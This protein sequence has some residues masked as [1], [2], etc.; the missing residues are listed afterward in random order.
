MPGLVVLL[1]VVVILDD[2]NHKEGEYLSLVDSSN[3][4]AIREGSVAMNS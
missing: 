3:I 2:V 1:L 4:S